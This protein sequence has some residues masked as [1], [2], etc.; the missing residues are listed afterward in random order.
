[1]TFPSQAETHVFAECI[2]VLF[3]GVQQGG[4]TKP[5]LGSA[6]VVLFWKW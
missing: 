6:A 5:N 4:K 3:F 1:M 2:G